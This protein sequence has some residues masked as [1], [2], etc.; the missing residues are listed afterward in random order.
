MLLLEI[1]VGLGKVKGPTFYKYKY[2]THF[3]SNIL[4]QCNKASES[5][6]AK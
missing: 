3:T 6:E 4:V 1:G 2:F 5:K